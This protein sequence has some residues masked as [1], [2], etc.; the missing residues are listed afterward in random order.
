MAEAHAALGRALT[1]EGQYLDATQE[2]DKAEKLAFDWAPPDT[3]TVVRPRFFRAL[4][5][6]R[7]DQP[8]KAGP[9]LAEIVEFRRRSPGRIPS[10]AL[11]RRRAGTRLFRAGCAGPWVKL[12]RV[13]GGWSE[14]I[15]ILQNAVNV[16]ER[17][18]GARHPSTTLARLTLAECY[19]RSGNYGGARAVLAAAAVNLTTIPAVHPIAAQWQYDLAPLAQ[20]DEPI[21]STNTPW[22][23][24]NIYQR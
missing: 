7:Q 8:Y 1:D 23:V 16:S 21:R 24:K 10:G 11:S 15:P 9:V 13:K 19:L 5:F 14:A 12:T 2:I 17:A 3:W 20:L 4:L 6:L 18:D 22:S